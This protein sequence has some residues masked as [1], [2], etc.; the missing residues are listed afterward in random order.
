MKSLFKNSSALFAAT[1]F[2]ALSFLSLSANAQAPEEERVYIK[3]EV[4]GL[5]CP[6]CAYGM[7]QDLLKVA[8]VDKVDIQLKEGLALLSTPKDQKPSKKELAQVIENGGFTVGKIEY[9]NKPFKIS[10]K[11]RE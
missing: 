3:I 9:S 5:A 7:E 8:G 4:F 2:F 1:L 6:Y 11:K 10:N